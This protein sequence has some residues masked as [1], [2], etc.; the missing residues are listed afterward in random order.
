M[1][2][3]VQAV[4]TCRAV[5]GGGR[6][7]LL[8]AAAYK[9]R[10][11]SAVQSPEAGRERARNHGLRHVRIIGFSRCWLV[12]VAVEP[13]GPALGSGGRKRP[14]QAATPPPPCAGSP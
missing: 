11:T 6:A 13:P 3:P 7:V 12:A 5:G 2:H 9:A 14:S 8:P 10:G 1:E 4:R